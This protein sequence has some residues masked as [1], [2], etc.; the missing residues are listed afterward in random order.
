MARWE[1]DARDRLRRA[2]LDLYAERGFEQTTVAE[3]AARA[4]VTERTF[5]RHFADKREVLFPDASGLLRTITDAIAAAP[6]STGPLDAV[7]DAAIEAGSV[8]DHAISR[9]RAEVI[10]ANPSLQE[11]ELL[12]LASWSAAAADALRRRGVTGS[13]AD[14]AARAGTAVFKTG[15]DQWVAGDG[16]TPLAACVRAA[17][18]ELK[19]TLSG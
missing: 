3:I 9:P 8:F 16:T 4:G 18:A 1:P 5:F 6:A 17:H 12:K 13:A 14:L 19:A 15:F 7:V 10:A 11:R 2:A